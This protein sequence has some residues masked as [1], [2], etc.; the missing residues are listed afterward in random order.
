[1]ASSPEASSASVRKGIALTAKLRFLSCLLVAVLLS[2]C[3]QPLLR[4]TGLPE[5]YEFAREQLVFHSDVEL[6]AHHRLVEELV[7]RRTDL[8]QTLMLP[9]SDEPIHVYVFEDGKRFNEFLRLHHPELPRRRAFFLETDTRLEVYAQWGDRVA[10]DL[11]HEIAH[12]YLHSVVPRLPV[13]LDEGLAEY[14]ELPRGCHGLNRPHLDLL[15]ASLD[16]ADWRPDLAR[17]ESLDAATAMT[18]LDYAEAWAWVHLLLHGEPA[19]AE[20]LREYLRE[21]C[22]EGSARPLSEQL[23]EIGGDARQDFV[24]HARR[25]AGSGQ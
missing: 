14:F 19:Q 23:G 25:L 24:A 4:R 2:G 6:P 12:A 9:V 20:L 8:S 16:R 21:L 10:E 3:G 18:Q 22:R 13:W 5:R 17:L 15:L 11:R 7:A 1:V